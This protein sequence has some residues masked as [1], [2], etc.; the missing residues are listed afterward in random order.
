MGNGVSSSL[1]SEF[2]PVFYQHCKKGNAF[3]YTGPGQAL[4]ISATTG[5]V[6]TVFNPLGSG[7]N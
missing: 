5:T 2:D 1:F 4:L 7:K 6:P 3:L